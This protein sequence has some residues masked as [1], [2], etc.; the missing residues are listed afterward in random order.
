MGPPGPPGPPELAALSLTLEDRRLELRV[1]LGLLDD[2]RRPAVCV[3]QPAE[4]LLRGGSEVYFCAS[5][6]AQTKTQ[7]PVN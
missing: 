3:R 6:L 1:R 2:R 5:F 4:D 7:Q